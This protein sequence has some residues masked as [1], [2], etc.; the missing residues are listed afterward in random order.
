MK[1]VIS[2][3]TVICQNKNLNTA[4]IDEEKVM[5][6]INKG[7]YYGLNSVG[8]RIW[9]L[10]ENPKSID[11]LVR[12]LLDEYEVEPEVCRDSVMTFI[13]KLYEEDM[14]SVADESL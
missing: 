6:D 12:N 3:N 7:R 11:E 13:N 2:N 1:K 4:D 5:M 8:T 14:I 10:I 9:E